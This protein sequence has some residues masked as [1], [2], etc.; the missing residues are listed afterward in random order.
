M[1]VAGLVKEENQL[2]GLT[3]AG[4][5]SLAAL[6]IPVKSSSKALPAVGYGTA[7]RKTAKGS[8]LVA[9]LL[10]LFALGGRHIDTALCTRTTRI[11]EQ[12][13]SAPIY[14][15]ASFGLR[16]RTRIAS[17]R[18][19]VGTSEP[20]RRPTTPSSPRL[21]SSEVQLIRCSSTLL[22]QRPTR[23]EV[24]RGLIRAQ[25][26]GHVRVLGVSNFDAK[27]IEELRAATGVLPAVNSF[28]YNPWCQHPRMSCFN[29]ASQEELLLLHTTCLAA[30]RIAGE[31][32]LSQS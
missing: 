16:P 10:D 6:V 28:E 3:A 17:C 23:V 1:L 32:R 19:L 29:G 30:R 12:L 20:Q 18:G 14:R 4:A 9:S 7:N 13:L 27:Q 31:G 24:W 8:R 25:Q 15:E 2:R 22:P 5:A 21:P 26:M 11:F